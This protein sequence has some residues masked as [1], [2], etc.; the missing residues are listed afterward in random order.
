[1][2]CQ[3][4]L[5]CYQL[6]RLPSLFQHCLAEASRYPS[7]GMVAALFA[8][9]WS[10]VGKN[11]LVSSWTRS[12]W[13]WLLLHDIPLVLLSCRLHLSIHRMLAVVLCFRAYSLNLPPCPLIEVEALLHSEYLTTVTKLA[14]TQHCTL[15]YKAMLIPHLWMLLAVDTDAMCWSRLLACVQAT[16]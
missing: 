14:R 3:E 15:S 2:C 16:A 13:M 10:I 5:K 1:M 6:P 11:R 7:I 8:D 9:W 12:W 4:Q